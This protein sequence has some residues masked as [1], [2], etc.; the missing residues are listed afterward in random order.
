[1]ATARDTAAAGTTRS[2][3]ADITG[4][5]TALRHID[6]DT[7]FR[8]RRVAVVGASDSNARP[9]TAL[10]QKITIWAEER[11]ATVHY[12]NP[13]RDVVAGRPCVK[14][15]TDVTEQ[16]DLVAILVGEP[17]P[18]L[19]DAVA[20]EAK[21]AVVFAAGFAEVGAKGEKLQDQMERI[22]ESG[23]LHV[24]GPN[25]NL[26][27]FEV[28][29]DDLG[30]PAIA[31]IT[32]SGHQ[33]RPVFQ[34][35][36]IGIKLSHWAPAGNEADMESADF[37]NYF[38]SLPTTGAIAC[39][40]EGFKNGRTLQLAAD[41]AARRKVPIVAV[42]VGR[43]D[44]G[45]SMAKAH[46]GHLTGSD[47]VVSAV[48]RQYGVQRVDGLDQL[49]EVSAALARTKPPSASATR[50]LVRGAG[51][52]VCVYSISG[53]TG[54][55]MADMV[56]AAGLE[57]PALTKA[58]QQQ[59]HEWIPPYLRVSNPV[60]NGGAPVRDWRGPRIIETMLADPNVDL[61]LCP[62]TGALPS[63]GNK[64][65][66]DL[67]AAWGTSDKPILVV[68]G[69]PVGTEE[70][71]T[72]TLLES[73]MPT[74][75]TFTNAVMAAKAYFDH[76]RFAASYQSAF[77]RPVRRP[78]PARAKAMPILLPRAA[79][80]PSGDVLSEQDSKALLK[81]Y[82]IAVPKERVATS[83]GEAAKAAKKVGFPVVMK[84]VSADIAHKSDLGLVA[85]GVRD[86]DDARR[87]Y[88]RLV[89]TAKKA[90]PQAAVDGVLV[91]ETVP[92]TET[93]VGIAR[94]DLFGPVVMF[95]LGGVLVEVLRDV[96]FRVPP[97]TTRDAT[98]MLNELRG[99]AL[100]RGVRGQ[101]PADRAA[102]V[103]VLM[104]MQ[105]LAVDLSEEVAELDINPLLAGPRGAVA[106]DA[107][108]VT[109]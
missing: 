81:A 14:A 38:S 24:L 83:S 12:V 66:E 13:N 87:T 10:T 62:I 76:H 3:R 20:A 79:R 73:T 108:V 69:S 74:F 21:F 18:I 109:A 99:A 101:P 43:T 26:N 65:C 1:M 19:R 37:I 40:I 23:E 104:K 68:W 59:L 93:V 98:A 44:E 82:G 5:A 46:T 107:L 31:L 39:Y 2:N 75:R 55:H 7:F 45:T 16:L 32:Q 11:G 103:D 106:A 60:D 54:A 85:V 51:G 56:A 80:R 86:E 50:R 91:A 64:L 57:L 17:L 90:A 89:A 105:H 61:L 28:F 27:A 15:L 25:T 88:K 67:V 47:D 71:Y 77:T 78:S 9:N 94:D 42:K 100:L 97:F 92:G 41:A 53:G 4:R 96:T 34:G 58:S 30:G 63:M 95:G 22:I 72:K 35:Q 52:R 102:L 70:A 84:I 29:R 6:L 8:P 36:E 49:L 48:F 33:G